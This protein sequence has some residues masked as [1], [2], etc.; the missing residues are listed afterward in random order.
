[1]DFI[2]GLLWKGFV[3]LDNAKHVSG[4][5]WWMFVEE[6]GMTNLFVKF[7][8]IMQFEFISYDGFSTKFSFLENR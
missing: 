2:A 3:V 8:R 4:W 7:V 6:M 1:M 5:I